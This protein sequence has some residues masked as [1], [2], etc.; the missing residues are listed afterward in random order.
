MEDIFEGLNDRQEEAVRHEFGPLLVL[1][2]AGSGKTRVLTH[3]IAYL[4]RELDYSPYEIMAVTFTNKAAAEMKERVERIVGQGAENIWVSTFHSSCVK[5]LRRF[6][7]N[8]GFDRNFTI[9]DSDDQKTL[10]RDIIKGMN[11]DPKKYKEKAFLSVISHAKDELINADRFAENVGGDVNMKLYSR[12]Y[13]EYQ[14]RLAANNALDFDD[15]IVKTIELFREAPETLDYYRRRFR[16]IL[17]DEYQ[18]TNTAQFELIRLLAEH[19]NEDG[20]KERNLCVVGDDDQ[21]I[22]KFRGANIRNILDFEDNYPEAK[23]IRLEQNYR[24]TKNILDV[25]NGIIHHNIGRKDKTL[26]TAQTGGEPVSYIEYRDDRE[27]AR[28]VVGKIAAGVN[29][30]KAEYGDYA[31]LYRT[32]AQS[33]I[34][35]E[36]LVAMN[37]PYRIIGSVNF[38]QRKEIKDMLA[39]LKVIDGGRDDLAVKRILNIPKRGIG[40]TTEEKIQNYAL[41]HEISFY[42]A[43]MRVESIPGT[44][45]AQAGIARFVGMIEEFKSSLAN[46]MK[47]SEIIDELL[48]SID[49]A[50]YLKDDDDDMKV[51]ERL[52]NIGELVSKLTEYENNA[53]DNEEVPSLAEFLE[54]VALVGDIDNYSEDKN[55]VVL[56]TIHSAKGL[57]FKNVFLVGMEEGVFPGYLVINSENPAEELE[58]ERR[59]CY[60]GVTRAREHLFLSSAGTR[61]MHGKIANNPPSRFINEIPRFALSKQGNTG[62]MHSLSGDRKFSFEDDE[63]EGYG[64]KRQNFEN[65]GFGDRENYGRQDSSY[66]FGDGGNY[67]NQDGSYRFG[68]GGNYGSRNNDYRFGEGEN[69][70]SRNSSYRFGEEEHHSRAFRE[71]DVGKRSTSAGISLDDNPYTSRKE[72]RDFGS[73]AGTGALGYEV[74]DSVRHGKFGIGTVREIVRGGKDYEVTVEFPSGVKKMM[75]GFAKLE[76]IE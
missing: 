38:Y 35:E 74:G 30:G 18:D 22:Y 75:A 73:G 69:R 9:Y 54:E 50:D 53:E 64:K 8:I 14:K 20:I 42:E 72:S 15:L 34:F 29:G 28:E 2:G 26:W 25:A 66:R 27:E 48:D 4:I 24:S 40:A 46:G 3:R 39:Y 41:E 11:L 60:V 31:I 7:E 6:I 44:G 32:N 63:K 21:S 49:Y 52:E 58:E 1:A 12:V 57:E 59:L 36:R 51:E 5:I 62:R 67:G 16:F 19:T 47:L 55:I 76:R 68:D 61:M 13:Y 71:Q 23:V 45:R 33:R 10:M 37:I 56:M 70:G 65:Y 17:V 43:L